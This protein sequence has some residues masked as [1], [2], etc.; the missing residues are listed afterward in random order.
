ML[1]D[2][3]LFLFYLITSIPIISV[4]EL[5]FLSFFANKLIFL[6][7]FFAFLYGFFS[8][9][10]KLIVR[11]IF[12][13]KTFIAIIISLLISWIIGIIFPQERPFLSIAC[14][15]L[16]VHEATPSFPSNHGIISFT[17]SFSFLFWFQKNWIGLLLFVISFMITG[18]RIFLCIHWPFDM[19]G[20]FILA[21]M[22]CGISQLFYIIGGYKLL[23]YIVKLYHLFS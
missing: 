7:F 13:Y 20:A 18:A 21:I 8:L 6:F 3:N 23:L 15:Y 14:K 19:V 12:F 9:K 10:K 11:R 22:A 2:I 4:I 1:N 16:L 17:I 5:K